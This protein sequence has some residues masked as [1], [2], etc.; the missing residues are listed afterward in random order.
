MNK[1]LPAVFLPVLAAP[2]LHAADGGVSPAPYKLTEIF[3]LPLTNSII[4]TWVISIALIV[5]LRLWI[6]RP[7][8]IP[9]K[10]QAVVE[11]LVGG[12]RRPA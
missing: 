11:E 6:G 10:G 2:T 3:G 4:T 9:N 5:A 1:L 8:L 7:K 12:L